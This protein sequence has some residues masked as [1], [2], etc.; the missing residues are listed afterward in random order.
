MSLYKYNAKNKNSESVEG[1]LE[2][3]SQAEAENILHSK[4]LM[5]VS[6]KNIPDR[7]LR[8]TRDRKVSLDALVIFSRQLATM[9]DSGITLVAALEILKD[10]IDDRA[11]SAIISKIYR[12]VQEGKSFCDSTAKYP[13]AFSDFYIN[14]IK[15]GEASGRLDEVLERLAVFLEKTAA[16]IRKVQSSLVYPA[17]II[18]MAISITVFLMVKVVPTFKGIFTTLGGELPVP[19]QI[20]IL[21][22]DTLKNYFLYILIALG[23]LSFLLRRYIKTPSG[24][25][26]FDKLTLKVPIFGPLFLKA[27][28]ARF[29]RTFSTLVKS[30]VPILN[31]LEI[32]SKT[33]GNKIIEQAVENARQ[34]IRQGEP[35]YQPLD[36]AN[37]FPAMVIRM[38]KV[39]EQAG[40][41]EKMLSKIADFYEEQV[42]VAVSS[43]TS[44]IEPLVIAVLGML[45]G[46]IVLALF[47]PI[48]KI[49]T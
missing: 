14:M 19:T 49:T 9:I 29:A 25:Q 18:T 42:D 16:L 13:A 8:K 12:D 5:I 28:V 21:A 43:M 15:A 7:Q 34:A 47:L 40:E 48:F 4:G 45:I 23:V 3:G 32:V 37:V 11:L 20:L 27:A 39:G 44:L 6:L 35:L 22:S 26:K 33:A 36:K 38:I 17:V 31:T 1:T 41:L 24:R 2:S 46:G 10:Q 30:G